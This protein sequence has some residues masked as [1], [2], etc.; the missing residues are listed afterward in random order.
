[1]SYICIPEVMCIYTFT[2]IHIHMGSEKE[3]E[4][5]RGREREREKEERIVVVVWAKDSSLGYHICILS[6]SLSSDPYQDLSSPD[7]TRL[8]SRLYNLQYGTPEIPSRG[9]G[10]YFL[11][12]DLYYKVL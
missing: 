1:M 2:Y 3:R 12:H 4:T 6:N 8:E 7:A 9:V 5:E 11:L 10:T